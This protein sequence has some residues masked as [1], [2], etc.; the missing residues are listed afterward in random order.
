MVLKGVC[1]DLV[2]KSEAGAVK[3][4]IADADGLRTAWNNIACGLAAHAQRL[5]ARL[6][7]APMLTGARGRPAA[8]IAALADTIEKL[9]ALAAALGPRLT[10]LDI[11]PLLVHTTGGGVIALDARATLVAAPAAP[12]FHRSSP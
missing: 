5:I 10:E 1:R 11:N 7:I 2:H 3:L 4:N 12:P 9:S 6:R 8:D